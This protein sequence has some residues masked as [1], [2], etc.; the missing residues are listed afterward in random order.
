MWYH[1]TTLTHVPLDLSPARRPQRYTIA[2]LRA[3]AYSQTR[4]AERV[5]V[6]R[7]T[8]CREFSRNTRG[9]I[10]QAEKAHRC[11]LK[12][13]KRR[14]Y[15]AKGLLWQSV[16]EALGHQHSPAQIAG[17]LKQQGQVGLSHQT[18]Y[19]AIYAD[20]LAGGDLFKNLRRR[21]KRRRKRRVGKDRRGG[22]PH[23]VS[24]EPDAARSAPP[25]SRPR[26]PWATGRG[27]RWWVPSAR[28]RS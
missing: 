16:V 4:I 21:H 15:K 12:R 9:R 27:T 3:E 24:I 17:R 5:G 11:A 22:I 28:G 20:R 10:Y 25:R 23:R 2:T 14:V 1:P 8:I 7:S 18:I 6:N 13:G 26:P 19:S